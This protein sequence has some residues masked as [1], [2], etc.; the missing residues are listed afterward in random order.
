MPVATTRGFAAAAV[1]G[2][3]GVV[4]LLLVSPSSLNLWAVSD[5][6]RTALKEAQQAGHDACARWVAL[7]AW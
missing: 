2:D 6:G 5:V 1:A 3:A 7:T 4:S